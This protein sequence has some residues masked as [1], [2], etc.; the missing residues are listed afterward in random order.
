MRSIDVPASEQKLL[1][2]IRVCWSLGGCKYICA[3]NN[4]GSDVL[5]MKDRVFLQVTGITSN[6]GPMVLGV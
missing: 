5:E 2:Y 6:A 3:L 4:H 1:L